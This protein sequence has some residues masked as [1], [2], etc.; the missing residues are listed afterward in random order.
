MAYAPCVGYSGK[1][2]SVPTINDCDWDGSE[3][4]DEAN[5]KPRWYEGR[6]GIYALKVVAAVA[7][8]LID[9][10]SRGR[11]RELEGKKL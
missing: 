6:L 3:A 5:T 4:E 2:G 10:T 11:I 1:G 7:G 9:F 8:I